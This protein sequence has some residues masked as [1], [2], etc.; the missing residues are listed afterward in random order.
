MNK[1]YL[2]TDG[3]STVETK[4]EYYLINNTLIVHCW[5]RE[6]EECPNKIITNVF[7]ALTNLKELKEHDD[8][9]ATYSCLVQLK[10][11][12]IKHVPLIAYGAKRKSGKSVIIYADSLRSARIK[13]YMN[14]CT[15]IN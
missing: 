10:D 11:N 2:G 9:R 15:L 1:I 13:A 12:L 4:S 8:Y 7:N 5:G 6:Y 14:N 3:D